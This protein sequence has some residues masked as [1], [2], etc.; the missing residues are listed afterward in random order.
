MTD[1]YIKAVCAEAQDP[2]N[3]PVV[4]R[5]LDTWDAM[6]KIIGYQRQEI[7][8]LELDLQRELNRR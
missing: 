5:L 1:E 3:R 6:I 8:K 2:L 4:P 7:A